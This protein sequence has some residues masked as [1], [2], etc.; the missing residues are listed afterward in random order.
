[1]PPEPKDALGTPAR[2]KPAA[3]T[4]LAAGPPPTVTAPAVDM[5]DLKRKSVRGGSVTLIFQ[6]ISIAIQ[7]TGTVILARLLSPADYGILAMVMAVT[8]FAGLFRDLGLSSAAIQK[9]DLTRA[10]QSNLFWL[11]VAMGTLLT[12]LVAAGSPLVV[13]F[14]GKPELLWVTIALSGSFLIG[15][16]GSQ[17]GAMLVRNMQFGRQAVAGISGALVGLA[18]SVTLAL[19]GWSYWA[20]VW[21]NLSGA[22]VTTILL[23]VLSPF[24]PGWFTMGSGIRD[25]LKFGANVTAFDFIN[26]FHRN[27]DNVLIGKFVGAGALGFYSRAYSLLMLPI[28]SLRG[29]INAVGFPALSRLQDQPAAYRDYYRKVTHILALA[30]MPFTAF[31]FVSAKEIIH[32]LLGPAW[33]GIMPI[34]AILALVAF[35]QPVLTLWGMVVLSRGMGRRYVHL[36]I[37]NTVCSAIGFVAGLPW[38]AVGVATGYAI[39]TYVTAIPI[40]TW[41][42]HGT[43]LRLRDFFA[44][45]A[46]PFAASVLAAGTCI[47]FSKQWIDLGIVTQLAV[48][49][50][51][52][53]VLYLLVLRALPGGR[54]DF[55][56]ICSILPPLIRRSV[57]S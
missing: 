37:F 20:L 17:H 9:K 7:L 4:T 56:L 48:S 51:V 11:N 53:G 26:Y 44:G 22:V 28:N 27:L 8:S 18:V 31:L 12:I 14:Y 42:F 49:A 39:V 1:L 30:S 21:G 50:S 29:P 10:Q 23:L 6:G 34:F 15:S 24:R 38:G 57:P 41:A 16:F 35:V 40:L 5:A 43:P 47:A 13:W 19:Q 2:L 45:T 3:A 55:R 46:R 25:M 52:F 33:G 36:G 32:L 54:G